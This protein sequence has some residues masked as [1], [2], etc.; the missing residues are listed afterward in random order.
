MDPAPSVVLREPVHPV[1]EF[2]IDDL[3]ETL[4]LGLDIPKDWYFNEP[5]LSKSLLQ[6]ACNLIFSFDDDEKTE[7]SQL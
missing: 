3:K 2:Y 1:H 7:Y 4:K 5:S 6:L